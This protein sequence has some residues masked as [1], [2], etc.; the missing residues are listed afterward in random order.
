MAIARCVEQYVHLVHLLEDDEF[1]DLQVQVIL[2]DRDAIQERWSALDAGQRARV[3]DADA[4]LAR[5]HRIVAQ[6]LPHPKHTDRRA[7]WWFLHEGPQ[8]REKAREAA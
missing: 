7:W 1:Y 3:E 2:T 4:A 8:V 6:M 5:K